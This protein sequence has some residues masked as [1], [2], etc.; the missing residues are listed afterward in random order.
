MRYPLQVV[1]DIR[2]A[3]PDGFALGARISFDEERDPGIGPDEALAVAGN[4]V[5][6]GAD[7]ISVIRG[8]IETDARLARGIPPMGTPARPHPQFAGQVKAKLSVPVM[9]AARI[10]DVATARYA[11]EAGL[12]DLVGMTR[13]LLA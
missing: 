12:L 6:A 9:H 2:A 4:V 7:F 5:A 13:A 1:A 3:V 11:I 8:S 10:A